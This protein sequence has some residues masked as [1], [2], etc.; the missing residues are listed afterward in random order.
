MCAAAVAH[1]AFRQSVSTGTFRELCSLLKAEAM[2]ACAHVGERERKLMPSKMRTP[3]RSK[4]WNLRNSM[5]SA[6]GHSDT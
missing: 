4:H 1:S 2:R 6:V 5:R 3:P